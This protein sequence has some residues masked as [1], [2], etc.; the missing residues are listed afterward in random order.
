MLTDLAEAEFNLCAYE[1]AIQAVNS[2]W[3][4]LFDEDDATVSASDLLRQWNQML[5]EAMM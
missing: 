2:P 1:F 3:C 4:C 5:N